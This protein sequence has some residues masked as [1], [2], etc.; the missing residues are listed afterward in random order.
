MFEKI[1]KSFSLKV[2]FAASALLICANLLLIGILYA[3]MP[4]IYTIRYNARA[5]A[6]MEELQ[7]GIGKRK[8]EDAGRY[9][10]QVCREY[11][12]NICIRNTAR[13]QAVDLP[14]FQSQ[15]LEEGK[16]TESSAGSSS[17]KV[18]VAKTDDGKEY[19]TLDGES[20]RIGAFSLFLSF[21]DTEPYEFLVYTPEEDRVDLFLSDLKAML[22]FLLSAVLILAFGA[23]AVLT[24][25]IA[26]PVLKISRAARALSEMDWKHS[27]LQMKRKDEIGVL[28][29]SMDITAGNLEQALLQRDQA[30]EELLRELEKQ[31][32]LDQKQR[33]FFAAASHELKTPV[34]VLK[35]QLTGMLYQVGIYR[36]RERYLRKSLKTVEEMER[37]ILKILEISRLES[38]EI[39]AKPEQI[40]LRELMEK[41]LEGYEELMEQKE[42]FCQVTV[43]RTLQIQ[44]DRGLFREALENLVENAVKYS[45]QGGEIRIAIEDSREK[46]CLQIE[47]TGVHIPTDKI[48]C[49]FQAFYRQEESRSKE[50]GG[51][52]LGLYLV[53]KALELQHISYEAQN[54]QEG[55]Q[56]SLWLKKAQTSEKLQT[57]S[58]ETSD[59]ND[60]LSV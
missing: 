16:E 27:R 10:Q 13:G 60:K 51:A 2:F 45:P 24:R 59:K 28:A 25:W 47:N 15:P 58:R 54:T 7:N 57:E 38:T 52:G 22:P 3:R 44:A 55:F 30:N 23:A 20:G 9:L 32:R 41:V 6:C 11:E 14:G 33:E 48:P 31:K 17:T 29:D 43:P 12:V 49:L 46:S 56:I 39:T 34:T 4:Q 1:R 42:I 18:Y 5:E 36:D 21:E 53:K 40:R 26:A 19:Q 8:M 37:R 50:T 35:G